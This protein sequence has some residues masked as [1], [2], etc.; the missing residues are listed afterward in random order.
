MG[1]KPSKKQPAKKPQFA[2]RAGARVGKVKAQAAGEELAR[3]RDK[4]GELTPRITVDE[5]KPKSAPLHNAFEWDNDKAADE[6]RLQQARTLIRAVC[7]VHSPEAE[8]QAVYVH[9]KREEKEGSYEPVSVVVHEPDLLQTAL[10]E[11]QEKLSGA[12]RAVNELEDAAERAGNKIAKKMA[13][14]VGQH[15]RMAA[16]SAVVA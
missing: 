16:E 2:F 12:Q 11:L 4:H 8:P 10:A 6:F 9:V 14:A 15:L 13:A 7:V 3:I 1:D 5:S